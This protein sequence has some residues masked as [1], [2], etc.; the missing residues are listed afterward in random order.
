MTDTTLTNIFDAISTWGGAMA[1]GLS[2]SADVVIE[3]HE[4][5]LTVQT[6]A[7][8]EYVRQIGEQFRDLAGRAEQ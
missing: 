4:A 8:N 6:A 3:R 7:I 2:A 5:G 1:S